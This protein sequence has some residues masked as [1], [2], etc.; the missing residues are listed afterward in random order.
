MNLLTFPLKKKGEGKEGR[1]EFEN[2]HD[3]KLP[4]LPGGL[5]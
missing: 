2:A 4:V 3:N 1:G 5:E